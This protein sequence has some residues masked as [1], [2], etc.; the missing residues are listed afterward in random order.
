MSVSFFSSP[1]EAP[2]GQLFETPTHRLTL[3]RGRLLV[4]PR[5]EVPVPE[6]DCRKVE[7]IEPTDGTRRIYVD[8]DLPTAPLEVR[9]WR[10]ADR[11]R[12]FGMKGSRLVSDFLADRGLSRLERPWVHLLVDA[13]GRVVWVIGLRADDRFRVSS[14]TRRVMEIALRD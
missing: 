10:A 13:E 8:A 2:S 9:P 1:M 3:H 6:G 5:G 14:A 7:A 4:C 11:F 12:P